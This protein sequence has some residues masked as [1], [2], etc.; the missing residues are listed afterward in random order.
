VRKILRKLN[1][2]GATLVMVIVAMLFIGI[3]SVAVL[4][5]AMGNFGNTQT[6][7]KASESFYTAETV[8]DSL[9]ICL[10]QYANKAAKEAYM[11]QL[12][13]GVVEAAAFQTSFREKFADAIKTKD[14]DD[15]LAE[16]QGNTSETLSGYT[17]NIPYIN[18]ANFKTEFLASGIIKNVE[19]IHVEAGTNVTTNLCSDFQISAVAPPLVY[20]DP[21]K[22]YKYDV[23]KYLFISDADVS[24]GDNL[25]EIG[26]VNNAM[27]SIFANGNINVQTS[28]ILN[29]SAKNII[30]SNK[31]S[32]EANAKGNF[33]MN[34][35]TLSIM[36]F[37]KKFQD[38]HKT[39][40]Y[41]PVDN[42]NGNVWCDNFDIENGTVVISTKT[43]LYLGD[44]LTLE[45]DGTVFGVADAG[46]PGDNGGIIAYSTSSK[47]SEKD[48]A[49][50]GTITRATAHKKSG[51]IVINGKNAKL[52]LSELEKL[53]LAGQAY[54]EIP[55]IAG[56]TTATNMYFAQGE[57]LTYKSLQ[58][59]YLVDGAKLYYM[60]GGEK[61]YIGSNPM[62]EADFE[63]W[64]DGGCSTD[65][66]VPTG[67]LSTDKFEY[68]S[69]Q[70]SS[71]AVYYYVYWKFTDADYA[72]GY[73]N[74][75]KSDALG[76][77]KLS[78]I[79]TGFIK[80]PIGGSVSSKGNLIGYDGTN[81]TSVGGGL[82]AAAS[83]ECASA[84]L[85]YN[86]I[87]TSLSPEYS[88]DNGDAAFDVFD[89]VLFAGNKLGL[90]T[91]GKRTYD[92][93]EPI[94]NTANGVVAI[95]GGV[96]KKDT[97]NYSY[98]LIVS[99][100]DLDFSSTDF[101]DTL[102]KYVIVCKGKVTFDSVDFKGIV[103]A[104]GGVK[105]SGSGNNFECL[106]NYMYAGE[107]GATEYKS[108]FDALLSVSQSYI[109][110]NKGA[111]KYYDADEELSEGSKLLRSIF[112]VSDDNGSDEDADTEY[113]FTSLKTIAFKSNY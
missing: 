100:S 39:G 91:T 20:V 30:S 68:K 32:T 112:G 77:Q 46:E 111:G 62:K 71:H 44:D 22:L 35:G 38:V 53:Y 78:A 61:V 1:N 108:E 104:K 16:I 3:I 106:G 109:D 94:Q 90:I 101:T 113:E 55:D 86:N 80:L 13:N 5:L 83:S 69:V 28:S 51:S 7:T 50:G 24:F 11:E 33:N 57:S 96:A 25:N 42:V 99:N 14:G 36:G 70:Y 15:L 76:K 21:D 98:K 102:T 60:D 105:V 103:F 40:S 82:S 59:I 74:S 81:F 18:E 65:A 2:S 43:N 6:V 31:Y 66:T 64:Y 79:G 110:A 67:V 63:K 97:K 88:M 26:G 41:D 85:Y 87:K 58:S 34:K 10:Q 84:K 89:S 17:I 52:D 48:E 8:N 73:F 12:A 47:A 92:L 56:S 4:A 37:G 27:G 93:T 9:K 19:V 23:D 72:V 45:G 49:V 54:T 75:V 107:G 29:L 95:E